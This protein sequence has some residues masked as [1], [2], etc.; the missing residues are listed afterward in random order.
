MHLLIQHIS[1]S[2]FQNLTPYNL[3]LFTLTWV[4][5]VCEKTMIQVYEMTRKRELR[6]VVIKVT[7]LHDNKI[8]TVRWNK[9]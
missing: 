4:I 5:R 9:H 2:F 3:K 8:Y 7:Y 6:T 1:R